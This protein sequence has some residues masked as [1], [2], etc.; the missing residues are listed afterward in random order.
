MPTDRTLVTE[1]VTGLGMLGYR[2]LEWA[3]ALRPVGVT[4][5]TEA[6]FDRLAELWRAGAYAREF[7]AAWGNGVLFAASTMGLRGRPPWVVEWKGEHRPPGYEQ[8]PADLRI[9]HVFLVSCKYGSDILTNSSPAN[10][11]DRLLADRR[12]EPVDWYLEVAPEA[13]RAFYDACRRAVAAQLDADGVELPDDPARLTR[14][15]RAVLRQRLGGRLPGRLVEPYRRLVVA[16]AEAS[17]VRWR[18][19][20]TTPRRREQMLW[21]LLR[22]Q[23]APYFVLGEAADGSSIRY[24]VGTPWDFKARYRVRRLAIEP[25]VRRRQPVVRWSAVVVG[26]GE[27]H[28]VEGHVEIRWSHG[29]FAQIPEAKVYLDTPHERVPGYLPL[30][31]A[32]SLDRLPW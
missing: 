3:L 27:E 8:V 18:E 9:D 29:R 20:L 21:R 19:R 17:A 4:N 32:P 11:F 6:H 31:V 30:E 22:L 14:Q 2:S 25:D 7:A 26:D 5:V 1:I 13:Y 16:V 10:L 24:M 12:V 23:P 15:Q 28:R